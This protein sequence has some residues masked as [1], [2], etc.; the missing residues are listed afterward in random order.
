MFTK[1]WKYGAGCGIGGNYFTQVAV[2]LN[3]CTGLVVHFG[4]SV[5]MEKIMCSAEITKSERITVTEALYSN[6]STVSF[7][8][9]E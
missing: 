1:I 9:S 7:H 2:T 4:Y 8:K 3:Y 6:W 5:S